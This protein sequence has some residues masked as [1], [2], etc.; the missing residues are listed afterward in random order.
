M[1]VVKIVSTILKFVLLLLFIII[2][3]VLVIP[4]IVIAIDAVDSKENNSFILK[5][6]KSIGE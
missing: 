4:F 5:L 3:A 6:F 2:S 1:Q